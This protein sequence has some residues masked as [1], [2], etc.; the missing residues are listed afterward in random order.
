MSVLLTSILLLTSVFF[1]TFS[2]DK[3]TVNWLFLNNGLYGLY[4]MLIA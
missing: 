4:W 2:R 3:S 1:L